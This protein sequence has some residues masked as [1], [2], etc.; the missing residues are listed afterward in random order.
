MLFR[1]LHCMRRISSLV[2]DGTESLTERTVLKVHKSVVDYLVS[3]RPHLDLRIDPTE[4]H[5][6]LTTACF[7]SIQ[8]LTFNVG[9]IKTSHELDTK[10]STVSQDIAY[11]C[12][13]FGHHLENGGE[14]ATLVPCVETFMKTHFLQWL[15][16]LS[17]QKLVDSVA[18]RTLKI[19][20]NQ[21]K[22][23]IQLL[24]KYG[25]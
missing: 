13:W 1:S 16:V 22:V 24:T 21:M 7:E 4:H 2:V 18:V 17:L 5:H 12:E 23:S 9:R 6:S 14:R 25:H 19:L 8:R 3:S 11:S 20:K 10:I 15:E